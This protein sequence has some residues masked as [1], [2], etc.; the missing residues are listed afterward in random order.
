[1]TGL[2]SPPSAPQKLAENLLLLLDDDDLRMRLAT[3]CNRVVS[4]L[5]WEQSTD[6]MEDFL[7]RVTH[8]NDGEFRKTSDGTVPA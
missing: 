6:L 1:M 8:T 5:S 4:K 7:A 2:L 3:A